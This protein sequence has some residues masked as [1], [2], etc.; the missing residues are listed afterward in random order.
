MKV[1]VT[2]VTG[3]IGGSV[4][5]ALADKGHQVYG[6]ARSEEH[7]TKLKLQNVELIVGSLADEDLLAASAAKVDG[8][9]NCADSDNGFAVTTFLNVLAGTGKFFIQTSG[10]ST[11]ADRAG[12]DVSDK[13]FHEDIPAEPVVEKAGR[14]AIDRY[15]LSAAMND[16]RSIVICPCLIYGD[17][18]GIKKDSQQVPMLIEYAKKTGSGRYIGSGLN[19]WSNV[20]IEDLAELYALAVEKGIAGSYFYAENGEASMKQVAE[21]I[22]RLLGFGGKTQSMT[23]AEAIKQWGQ[24]A[25]HYALASNSRIRAD[26]ARKIL[27]WQP[28][29]RP[30]L[31]DIE[32]GSYTKHVVP[33]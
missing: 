6:L 30:L 27:G 18:L 8:V 15:V 20:H 13:V 9:V 11:V 14:V 1:L 22:S 7:R 12:G 4:A 23:L 19:I 32:K 33:S 31:E 17:G 2:G 21:S 29:R 3:Y 10:S 25:A 5:K 16:V 26:K 24:G 28:S